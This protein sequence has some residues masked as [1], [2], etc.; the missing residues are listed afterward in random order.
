MRQRHGGRPA[1]READG[2]KRARPAGAGASD[3]ITVSS[4]ITFQ[5]KVKDR[6]DLKVGSH[7]GPL[8]A[9]T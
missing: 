4:H 6:T 8:C 2:E 3:F 7:Y 5:Q 9:L 1:C